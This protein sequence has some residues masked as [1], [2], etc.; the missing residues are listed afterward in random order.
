MADLHLLQDKS[1][2]K[3]LAKFEGQGLGEVKKRE[4][5]E[6]EKKLYINENQYF[7]GIESQVWNYY[8]GG[9]QVLDKWIKDKVGRNLNDD[10]VEHYLKVITA[11]SKTIEIQNEI[12]K[13]YS[14]IE[15]N[16]LVSK[17]D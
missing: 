17:T 7:S 10:E 9:Y 11:I 13:L 3:S 2:N 8:I 5:N 1:L 4:Y 16:L 6:K 12:D 14:S 15:Q